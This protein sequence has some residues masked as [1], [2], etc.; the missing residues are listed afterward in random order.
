[1]AHLCEAGIQQ[2]LKAQGS[3]VETC[4]RTIVRSVARV[5]HQQRRAAKQLASETEELVLKA[6]ADATQDVLLHRHGLHFP[7]ASWYS[8][9]A[10]CPAACLVFEPENV[11]DKPCRHD[12][13]PCSVAASAERWKARHLGVLQETWEGRE[14]AERS[15]CL[16]A[17]FCR[18]KGRGWLVNRLHAKLRTFL[19]L[20]KEVE[21]A[22][23]AGFVVL[24]FYGVVTANDHAP[25][26]K[27]PKRN[28]SAS[29][30]CC[31]DRGEPF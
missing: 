6:C 25:S 28:S 14:L 15:F 7:T 11:P 22:M 10:A 3:R 31:L 5:V 20:N 23:S 1:M 17:G 27:R 16:A 26:A 13:E 30:S 4:Y 29:S 21:E 2:A 8:F 12:G 24:Q 19:R 9:P 18:C